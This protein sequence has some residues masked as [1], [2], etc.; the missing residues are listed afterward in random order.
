M[1]CPNCKS[2]HN[3][4]FSAEIMIHLSGSEN[5]C[6]PGVLVFPKILVCLACG[7]S[8]FIIPQVEVALMAK[9][10]F[11]SEKKVRCSKTAA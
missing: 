8:L 11:A 9:K 6:N 3:G 2:N 10:A 1:E 7:F 5:L 4:Q